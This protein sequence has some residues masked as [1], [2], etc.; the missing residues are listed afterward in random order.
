MWYMHTCV[1]NI[2]KSTLCG[3]SNIKYDSTVIKQNIPIILKGSIMPFCT[4]TP[5]CQLGLLKTANIFS[6][7]ILLPLLEIHTI[8]IIL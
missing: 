5:P 4:Q 7:T 1:P 6:D 3:T 2:S 8:G